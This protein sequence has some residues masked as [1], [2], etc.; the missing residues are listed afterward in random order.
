MSHFLVASRSAFLIIILI[1]FL[2]SVLLAAEFDLVA[3][4][5]PVSG[6]G[7]RQGVELDEMLTVSGFF[8]ALLAV[9]AWL[10]GRSAVTDR[11]AK[12]ALE[13]TAFL[14]PLTGLSNRRQFNDRLASALARFRAEGLPCAVL[15]IEVSA[16]IAQ[17]AAVPEDA[18]RL[19]GDEFAIILRAL[20]ASEAA[21]RAA[22]QR[23]ER[24]IAEA[25]EIEGRIV[26]PS[27]SIGLAFATE[28][29]SRV[30]DLLETADQDMY[31][32]KRR[33]QRDLAA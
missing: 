29:S 12:R 32:A 8:S 21:A 14:D 28:R 23:L 33:R 16:R 10:N 20:A 7:R 30:S 4:A 6:P 18:A 15:L 25:V 3:A 24:A 26:H 5:E 11:R 17:F 2:C 13:S 9:V 27:A 22:V 1:A 19:G 31:C